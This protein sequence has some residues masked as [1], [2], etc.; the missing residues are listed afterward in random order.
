M[1]LAEAT[2]W[3]EANIKP[4]VLEIHRIDDLK[5]TGKVEQYDVYV[6]V[7]VDEK[8]LTRIVSQPIHFSNGQFSLADREVKNYEKPTEG[9]SIE[10]ELI[11]YL[12]GEFGAD[13]YAIGAPV[14][15][16]SGKA[17]VIEVGGNKKIMAKVG[18]EILARNFVG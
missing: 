11:A 3:A 17:A 4:N 14:D 5:N 15:T 16:T 7:T 8:G 9:P 6:Q 1:G 10:A 2:A 13:N 18:G 12:D